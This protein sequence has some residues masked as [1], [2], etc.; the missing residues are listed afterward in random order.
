MRLL[1]GTI[2]GPGGFLMRS[3]NVPLLFTNAW[4]RFKAGAAQGSHFESCYA[5]STSTK[6]VY[7]VALSHSRFQQRQRLAMAVVAKLSNDRGTLC[8]LQFK[9]G[10]TSGVQQDRR[11]RRS[12]LCQRVLVDDAVLHDDFEAVGRISHQVDVLQRIALDEQESRSP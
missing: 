10:T 4:V 1:V 3:D 12:S 6:G 11:L 5:G 8:V 7:P 9:H 2:L